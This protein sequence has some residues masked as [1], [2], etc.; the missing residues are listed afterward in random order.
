MGILPLQF[1]DGENADKHGLSGKETFSID[2]QGGDLKV[3]QDVVI[4][5]SNGKSITVKCRLDTDPEINYYQNG[6]I[7]QS[8]LRKLKEM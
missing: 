1:K 5:C 7:L 2:T 4:K 6:G 3:G 8:V